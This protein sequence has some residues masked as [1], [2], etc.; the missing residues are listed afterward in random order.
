M[1]LFFNIMDSFKNSFKVFALFL[2]CAEAGPRAYSY[3]RDGST[4]P[5]GP[6]YTHKHKGGLLQLVVWGEQTQN[7]IDASIRAKA[8]RYRLYEVVK[9]NEI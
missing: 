7:E 4:S 3:R 9:K 6:T 5:C 1:Y 8:I 2:M